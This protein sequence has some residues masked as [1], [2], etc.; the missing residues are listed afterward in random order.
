MVLP[1]PGLRK[2]ETQPL[3]KR[4]KYLAMLQDLKE[5]EEKRE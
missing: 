5:I 3:H 2:H 1:S 4:F